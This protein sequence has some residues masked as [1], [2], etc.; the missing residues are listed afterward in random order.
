MNIYQRDEIGERT[1]KGEPIGS[2]SDPEAPGTM[3]KSSI[4]F[5]GVLGPNWS[6][7]K[8]GIQIGLDGILRSSPGGAGPLGVVLG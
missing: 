7:N 8:K 2:V 1:Q 3:I 4:S 6:Y 5:S